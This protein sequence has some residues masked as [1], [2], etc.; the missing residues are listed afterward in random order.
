M[1]RR[2]IRKI[3]E[4][5]H[6]HKIPF[7]FTPTQVNAALGINWAGTFLPKHRVCNPSNSSELFIRIRTGLY[8]LNIISQGETYGQRQ[9]N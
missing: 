4:M 8:K 7:E 6:T 5:V 3:R 2:T 1:E 9:V